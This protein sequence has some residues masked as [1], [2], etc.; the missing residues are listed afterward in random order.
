MFR[1]E[2]L[3]T[4]GDDHFKCLP[5]ISVIHFTLYHNHIFLHISTTRLLCLVLLYACPTPNFTSSFILPII[6]ARAF[7]FPIKQFAFPLSTSKLSLASSIC[8]FFLMGHMCLC[9][10]SHHLKAVLN[11]LI[12]LLFLISSNTV[13]LKANS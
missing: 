13:S 9:E 5:A 10:I 3:A 4:Y 6:L 11:G 12:L 2:N 7:H 8:I 1:T